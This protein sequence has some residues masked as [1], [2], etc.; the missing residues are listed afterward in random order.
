MLTPACVV[1]SLPLLPLTRAG[2]RS[3]LG[4]PFGMVAAR[5]AGGS[6][7]ALGLVESL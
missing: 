1:T 6:F 5:N 4:F 7:F 2:I 3:G